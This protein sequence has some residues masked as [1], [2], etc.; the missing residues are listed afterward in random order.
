M[1]EDFLASL[2][3]EVQSGRMEIPA[4]ID[5][6][7]NYPVDE[8]VPN[9]KIDTQ[10]ALRTSVPE[11]VFCPG[12]TTEQVIRI[13]QRLYN[14]H[15]RALGTRASP[16]MALLVQEQIPKAVYDPVSRLISIR[17]E[18]GIRS[19]LPLVVVVSAGT[20]D[21]PIAE[22]AA[23]TLEFLCCRVDRCY[24]VGVA[25]LH[26]LLSARNRLE[27]AAV[28]ISVA[29]MEGALTSVVA[30]LLSAPVIGVPTSVGYGSNMKGLSALLA[31]LNSCAAG[32]AV[33]NI[34]NGFGAALMAYAILKQIETEIAPKDPDSIVRTGSQSRGE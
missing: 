27:R 21:V 1:T 10:R 33:V 12:K 4:A 25:G 7:S 34:D 2:L 8:T 32:V 30:G 9:V 29:G 5:K 11:V 24:D 13:L 18:S 15:G 26:R 20:A 6:L 28:V 23:Q 14:H 19:N 22:E 16:K 3:V 17:R 31:M